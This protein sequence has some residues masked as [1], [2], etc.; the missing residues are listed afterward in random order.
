MVLTVKLEILKM[1]ILVNLMYFR[2]I[3]TLYKYAATGN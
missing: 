1:I 3:T 2:V